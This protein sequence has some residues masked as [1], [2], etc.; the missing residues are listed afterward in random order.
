MPNC[1]EVAVGRA[2]DRVPIGRPA[3]FWG[4][5]WVV[6]FLLIAFALQVGL[7]FLGGTAALRLPL[8]VGTYALSIAFPLLVKGRGHPHTARSW[9]SAA[10]V[11]L[12]V[13]ALNPAGENV[14]ARLASVV[15]YTSVL[16]PLFW[17][18]RLRLGSRDFRN[19]VR[20]M[21]AFYAASAGVGVLQVNYP[22]RF[23]GS[24]SAFIDADMLSRNI[25]VMA[26]GHKIIRPQGLTDTPGG[27]GNGGLN[28]IVLGT[29]L[30]LTETSLILRGLVVAGMI[31]G[32]FCIY[33]VQ[34]RTNLVVAGLSFLA[35]VAIL[36]R[37]K[38][39][40]RL[41]LLLT[42]TGVVIAIGTTVA[43][44]V[45]GEKLID[46]FYTL[47]S[48]DPNNVYQ[49]NR[50]SFLNEVIEHDVY[51]YPLGAGLGHWGM[52]YSYFGSSGQYLWAEM[53]WQSL[54]YD[55]GVVLIAVYLGLFGCLLWTNWQIAVR[56][57]SNTVGTWGGVVLGYN[58]T[59]V[60]ASF[61]FPI[62]ALQAGMEVLL[63]NACLFSVASSATG[64]VTGKLNGSDRHQRPSE[65]A[66]LSDQPPGVEADR[67]VVMA[68]HDRQFDR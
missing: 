42:V 55:G 7:Y 22:G 4:G 34:E 60:A 66:G 19:I 12:V 43:F 59:A 50:G 28:A 13:A 23:E 52:V 57:R 36:L 58:V 35:L 62:L 31:A 15:L 65:L 25:L 47:I 5:A 39:F 38:L 37:R 26:D 9:A 56:A 29:G 1:D 30:L 44:A 54:V 48:D 24:T 64:G 53:L 33:I 20:I 14:V 2:V 49:Q 68:S 51:D 67:A 6:S 8:R 3:P 45:G 27:A 21:W 63:L 40:T 17:V 41:A 18:G 11:I 10:I 61:V 16:A 32:L 46:R